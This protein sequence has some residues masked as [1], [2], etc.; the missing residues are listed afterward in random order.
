MPVRRQSTNRST[1]ALL[2][3]RCLLLCAAINFVDAHYAA[4][5]GSSNREDDSHRDQQND[6]K[7]HTAN[8]RGSL[9]RVER[10]TEDTHKETGAAHVSDF[11]EKTVAAKV[12]SVTSDGALLQQR[13]DTAHAA[14]NTQRIKAQGVELAGVRSKVSTNSTLGQQS[15]VSMS[16][17]PSTPF[18]SETDAI[19]WWLWPGLNR[20]F[21]T[22]SDCV[23][24]AQYQVSV[25]T[26]KRDKVAARV[27]L[28]GAPLQNTRSVSGN[29]K[30]A[31]LFGI[32]LLHVAAGTHWVGVQ[33]KTVYPFAFIGDTEWETRTLNVLTLPEAQLDA[34]TPAWTFRLNAGGIWSEWQGFEQEL[35]LEKETPTFAFYSTSCY[36][37]NTMMASKMFVDGHEKP[38]TRSVTGNTK[39][40]FT[41]GMFID[42]VPAGSH[43]W[44]VKYKQVARDNYFLED[45][46]GRDWMNRNMAVVSLP[47]ALLYKTHDDSAFTTQI[48]GPHKWKGLEK[49][50]GLTTDRYV[51]ATY[52][53]AWKLTTDTDTV[54]VLKS[55]MVINGNEMPGTRSICGETQYCTLT[56]MWM[57]MLQAG[58]HT[59][60]AKYTSEREYPMEDGLEDYGNRNLNIIVLS[61]VSSLLSLLQQEERSQ[62]GGS[63]STSFIDLGSQL[64]NITE[65]EKQIREGRA[66]KQLMTKFMMLQQDQHGRM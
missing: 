8:P 6:H 5:V 52:T 7:P 39:F 45:G 48:G 50:I 26:D 32:F 46:D 15:T 27:V 42:Y 19:D 3:F 53:V 31:N 21:T 44:T 55:H 10:A 36:G 59:F 24:I 65:M 49:Q 14:D 25:E 16:V 33:Y 37:K 30:Y 58:T 64:K 56:G 43:V 41:F 57:G 11:P 22:V 51:I 38:E 62:A 40:A 60:K 47:D 13:R 4:A 61:R 34:V 17:H 1:V 23:V 12:L 66:S 20:T 9:L 35:I 63:D 2:A 28:D 29:T 18:T 54:G